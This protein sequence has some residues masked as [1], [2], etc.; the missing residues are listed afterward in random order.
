MEIY[1]IMVLVAVIALASG[2]TLPGET[3]TA[4]STKGIVINSLSFNPSQLEGMDEGVLALEIQNLGSVT[5]RDVKAYIYGMDTSNA[6]T[7]VSDQGT[8]DYDFGELNAPDVVNN[9]PSFPATAT[10]TFTPTSPAPEGVPLEYNPAV[11]V[12][13]NYNATATAK[14]TVISKEEL[15]QE[16]N[17]GSLTYTDVSTR[18]SGGPISIDITSRQPIVVSS[19]QTAKTLAVNV[20]VTN[21]DLT[22]GVVY[23]PTADCM[24]LGS[25]EFN[26]VE[27]TVKIPSIGETH[28]G[29]IL[30]SDGKTGSKTFTFSNIPNDVVKQDMDIIF[31]TT[32]GYSVDASTRFMQIEDSL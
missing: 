4:V 20:K 12:C 1:K 14:F 3:G 23:L 17:R 22:T 31:K 24:K 15:K 28:T 25:G 26:R 5:A 11:R 29:T 13:Y 21:N 18:N 7:V 2:C 9:I 16:R 6:W 19:T 10:W 30:L 32:Y 27:V 8:I